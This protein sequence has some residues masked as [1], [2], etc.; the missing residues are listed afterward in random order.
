MNQSA[1]ISFVL[2]LVVM[3][4]LPAISLAQENP[5]PILFDRDIKPI[6]QKHCYVC[7]SED[8]DEDNDP[9]LTDKKETMEHI[10]KGESKKSKFY[11]VLISEG[12]DQMP[13]VDNDYDVQMLS[14]DQIAMFKR[15]IDEGA[16]WSGE[17]PPEKPLPKKKDINEESIWLHLWHAVGPFH[18]AVVHFPVALLIVSALFAIGALRG[19]YVAGDVAYYCL[20]LGAL[21]AIAA[22]ALG[23]SYTMQGDAAHAWDDFEKIKDTSNRYFWHGLGGIAV[24]V[25]SL[26]LAIMA[27]VSRRRDADDNGGSAWKIGTFVVAG[28]VGWVGH[29]GGELVNSNLYDPVWEFVDRV[30]GDADEKET[31]K[32]DG[33]KKEDADKK[34]D[35]DKEKSD[36][37]TKENSG[38]KK[39]A[40]SKDA[41]SKEADGDDKQ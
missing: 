2:F 21:S 29:E 32:K 30:K 37:E 20:W 41:D 14:P 36:D 24:A 5:E 10:A 26:I 25:L 23:W 35:A 1:F 19:S 40:D 38:D 6:L 7:H 15:W 12:D 3:V 31:D 18:M 11:Q 22:V 13:P 39:D 33:D 27:S 9:I 28:L 17:K 8:G 16:L 34:A 4:C